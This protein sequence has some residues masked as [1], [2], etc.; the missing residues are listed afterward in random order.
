MHFQGRDF[1]SARKDNANALYVH[2]CIDQS[3]L[4]KTF[5]HSVPKK[6]LPKKPQKSPQNK[7]VNYTW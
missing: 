1:T 7:P 6:T 2:L 4:T 5:I 3:Y